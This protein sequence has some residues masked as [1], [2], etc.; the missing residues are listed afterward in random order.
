MTKTHKPVSRET[1]AT[2][3]ERS[4]R[5]PIV[6]TIFPHGEIGFRLKGTRTTYA[7]SIEGC[8]DLAV[9]TALKAQARERKTKREKRNSNA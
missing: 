9:K 6:V 8:F 7:L 5:R 1:I 2:R 4:Q 3:F